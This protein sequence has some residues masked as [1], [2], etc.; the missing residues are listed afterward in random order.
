MCET[1]PLWKQAILKGIDRVRLVYDS[2]NSVNHPIGGQ[3]AA[4]YQLGLE[5]RDLVVTINLD[6]NKEA[7]LQFKVKLEALMDVKFTQCQ[8]AVEERLPKLEMTLRDAFG[9]SGVKLLI[10]WGFAQHPKFQALPTEDKVKLIDRLS[11]TQ[12]QQL[13]DKYLPVHSSAC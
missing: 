4:W 6:K 8:Q 1:D 7:I 11:G 2:S 10:D 9:T 12:C 3:Y 13:V 5:N